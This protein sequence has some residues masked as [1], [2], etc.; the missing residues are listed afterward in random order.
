MPFPGAFQGHFWGIAHW[1]RAQPPMAVGT[2]LH[3]FRGHRVPSSG[4]RES[5]GGKAPLGLLHCLLFPS[6]LDQLLPQLEESREFVILGLLLT[7][8]QSLE[9]PAGPGGDSL[10]DLKQKSL[11]LSPPRT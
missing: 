2:G 3:V 10:H 11:A 9:S 1:V 5:W 6:L 4:M 8:H 7:P